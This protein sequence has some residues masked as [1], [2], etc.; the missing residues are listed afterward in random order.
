MEK[1]RTQADVRHD[2]FMQH[3]QKARDIGDMALRDIDHVLAG[4]DELLE[5]LRD[6]GL[7]DEE[8]GVRLNAYRDGYIK[9]EQ[10]K[11]EP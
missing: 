10:A 5:Q 3:A 8:I 6:A 4:Q 7:P 11:E 2:E 1:K 9:R